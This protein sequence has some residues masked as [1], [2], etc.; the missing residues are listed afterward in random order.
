MATAF[1]DNER[2]LIRDNLNETAIKCLARYGVRK[3][4][5]DKIVEIVG[6]SKGSFYNFYPKKEIL[7]FTVLEDYQ[8]SLIN[9]LIS[10]F[11]EETN[12][13]VDKFTELIYELYQDVRKSFV[14][15]I[16]E[17]HEFEYLMGKL[18]K[19]LI[20]NHHGLDNIL[21]EEIFTYVKIK[22]NI[23]TDVISAGLRAIFTTMIF[24]EEVGEKHFD[25]VLKLLIKGLAL[26]IIEE[27]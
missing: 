27:D 17:N 10:K 9:S 14:M 16:I 20:E 24:S 7:F 23:N 11:N 15:N 21:A 26:Q 5:V 22:K 2:K 6:I 8:K 18:P 25:K 4:T 13:N 1:S 12:I 3:T 19:E